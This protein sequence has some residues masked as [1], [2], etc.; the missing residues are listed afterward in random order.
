MNSIW[1]V[2][3]GLQ[4]NLWKDNW[5]GD[6]LVDILG[7]PHEIRDSLIAKSIGD[8]TLSMKTDYCH[9]SKPQ[10]FLNWCKI[11]WSKHIPPSKSFISWR[12]MH[13]RFPSDENQANRGCALASICVLCKCNIDDS[14]H[15]FFNYKFAQD[16]WNWLRQV[17]SYNLNSI[18]MHSLL[19]SCIRQQI[20]Q[21]KDVMVVAITHIIS[22]I[23]FCRN[24]TKFEDKNIYLYQFVAKIRRKD[25]LSGQTVTTSSSLSLHDLLILKAFNVIINLNRAPIIVEVTWHPPRVGW[26]KVNTNGANNGSPRQAGY[27]N[28]LQKREGNSCADKLAAYGIVSR[29]NPIWFNLPNFLSNE[30]HR[31]RLGVSRLSE[32]LRLKRHL[33]KLSVVFSHE[34]EDIAQATTPGLELYLTMGFSHKH[35]I[36]P[37]RQSKDCDPNYLGVSRMSEILRLKRHL[38]KLSLVFSP[39]REVIAQ[40]AI[41]RLK[42]DLSAGFSPKRLIS[43]KRQWPNKQKNLVMIIGLLQQN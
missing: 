20:S 29:R 41:P 34:R 15:L 9:I 6:S 39:E 37:K 17:F 16:L 27:T 42:S 19:L 7:I 28:G 10:L 30:Y 21:V 23:W 36:S 3:D 14:D 33:P 18:S 13:N 1:L 32:I 35:L 40:A 22:T 24:Q 31:N 5:I 11:L 2:G 43:P 26:L 38:A 25:S 4:V 12:L 8:G